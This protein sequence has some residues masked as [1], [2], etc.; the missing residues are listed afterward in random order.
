MRRWLR[1]RRFERIQRRLILPRIVGAFADAYPEAVFVEVGS[2]DGEQ[3]DH[4][5]PHILAQ[6]WRGVMVE[7]VP[8]VF[9]RLRANYAD[10]DG[11]ALENAAIADRDGQLPFFHLRDA[12]PEERAGL[13]DWYDGVGSFDRQAILSH[14]PQMPDI[15][16]RIVELE[17]P[18]LTFASLLARH[19]IER[20]DLV[21]IDTEGHDWEIIKSI[22]LSAHGPRLL[23]FEHFH[24]SRDDRA[25]ARAH[26]ETAGYLVKEEGFDT[27]ALRPQEDAL[28]ARFVKAAPAVRGVAKYEE[29]A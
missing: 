12:S 18:A 13:P 26:L 16:E 28:T 27:I 6:R 29:A 20:P 5:R 3:H 17:V 4:L 8:Y 10:V 2:N 19:G 9:E 14:A 24:L 7:P 22:D 1:R 15:A 11:V 21:V 23:I 25:S